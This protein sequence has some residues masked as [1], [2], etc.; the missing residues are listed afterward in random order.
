MHSDP[1]RQL[2]AE[3]EALTDPEHKAAAQ[4]RIEVCGKQFALLDTGGLIP[5][6]RYI[7]KAQHAP[8]DEQAAGQAQLAAMHELLEAC[9]APGAWQAFEAH[10]IDAKASTADISPAIETVI[11]LYTARPYWAGL[12]LLASTVD[13]LGELD[14]MV[15]R[16]TGRGLASFTAREVCNLMLTLLLEGKDEEE[17]AFLLEDLYLPY[18]PEALA[19]EN[20]KRMMADRAAA[21][22]AAQDGEASHA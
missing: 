11:S 17:R 2:Q 18:S 14:G 19:L 22:K 5:L 21:D 20:V 1:F 9:V 13:R 8:E 6:L 4:A 12:R 3:L 16:G 7:G 15:L 10:C